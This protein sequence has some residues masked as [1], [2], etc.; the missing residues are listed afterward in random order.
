[1]ASY[2]I[3]NTVHILFDSVLAMDDEGIVAIFEALVASGLKGFLGCPVVI[4]EVALTEFF[5]HGSIRDGMV[6]STIQGKTVEITE[7]VFAGT[8]EFPIDGLTDLN[9][10]LKD[11]VFDARSIFSFF[12]QQAGSFDAVTHE[13]FLMM[14]AINGGIQINW[15]RVLFNIFKDMVTPG[16]KQGR[17]YAV[18]ICCLLKK[19]QDLELG[20][21]KAFPP[22]KKLTE[23][24]VNR[25]IS[26]NDKISVEDVEGMADESRVKKTPIM[27]PK[28][29][30]RASRQVM[31]D[32]RTLVSAD[33][34]D[35]PQP[36]VPM[37][38]KRK[39]RASR[40]VMVDSRTLVS[41]DREDVPQPSVPV[42]CRESQPSDFR[43][44]ASAV[45]R[46]VDFMES[47]V[48]GQ[49]RVRQSTGHSVDL[50][51]SGTSSSQ[52]SVASQS[53][54]SQRFRPRGRQFKRSSSSSSS[55][56]GSSGARPTASFC[57]QCG[58]K[59]DPLDALECEALAII[60]RSVFQPL[61]T[62]S[63]RELSLSEQP[64]IQ[65]TQVDAT[66]EERDDALPEGAIE[67]FYSGVYSADVAVPGC[68]IPLRL[69]P[70]KKAVSKKRPATAVD[71]HIS[72]KKRTRVGK[73]A[74]SSA[75][76]TVAQE[77][78]PLQIVE[79]IRA[80]PAMLPSKPKR[81]A[82]KRRL[83]WPSGS[84]DEIVK[85]IRMLVFEIEPIRAVPA[86]LPSKPKR[87]A[88]KRRLKWP[89]G[90]D[91]EIVKKIRMLVA[92]QRADEMEHWFNVSYEE[93]VAREADRMVESGSDTD[94][95]IVTDKVTST[96]AGY[97]GF[98]AG[99]GVDPAGNASGC[100]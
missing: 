66:I 11:L 6:V 39:G 38:P 23:K 53:L 63:V 56:G 59:H 28:R 81:K 37:P 64:G 36:S 97:H 75:I 55:S 86:M 69:T 99:R 57:G 52:F 98:S 48:V 67:L 25:Y 93:F 46:A 10:V 90:S 27:P 88:P 62:S 14:A 42:R 41:A 100:G 7:E 8:F 94:E 40:Q 9:E 5:Q 68:I 72:K 92:V 96:Y 78:I 95:E 82:P 49:T 43:S 1:M 91:D 30:G 45:N 2:L 3:S 35:V 85:K 51:P 77:A 32:S 26:I 20:D 24:T 44:L 19:G 4:Y 12:C 61:E 80:V 79:P 31:V 71:E 87:K 76:V 21:F 50:V 70:M 73:A 29:K 13:I 89:S 17:G 15:S 54:I 58:G 16:S 34:E 74:K 60:V 18:Q 47:L 84:D 33:R 65:P 83:K 22:L